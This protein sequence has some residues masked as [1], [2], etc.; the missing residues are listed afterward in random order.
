MKA[1]L[2][3][4]E[5]ME[6]CGSEILCVFSDDNDPNIEKILKGLQTKWPHTEFY[7]SDYIP[8]CLNPRSLIHLLAH[9]NEKYFDEK[10]EKYTIKE[11]TYAREE[12]VDV[13]T[14][15]IGEGIF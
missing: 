15:D 8:E 2:F 10:E 5:H 14:K 7:I 13:T 1:I 6:S 3:D 11:Y 9:I 4:W 12:S